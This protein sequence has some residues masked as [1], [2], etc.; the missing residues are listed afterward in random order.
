MA[1]GEGRP[2]SNEFRFPHVRSVFRE[3]FSWITDKDRVGL[4][5][6]YM[7]CADPTEVTIPHNMWRK[8]SM[9]RGGSGISLRSP[10]PQSSN[11][12]KRDNDAI[13]IDRIS[14][15]EI[16]EQEKGNTRIEQEEHTKQKVVLRSVVRAKNNERRRLI[17][18]KT[19]IALV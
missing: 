3:S 10:I 7:V 13:D 18:R 12:H 6:T 5:L 14:A 19:S 15:R 2:R 16:V 17:L 8:V 4:K 1:H 11:I 9:L